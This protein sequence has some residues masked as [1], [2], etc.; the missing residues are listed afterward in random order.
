MGEWGRGRWRRAHQCGAQAVG[1]SGHRALAEEDRRGQR[2]GGRR[3]RDAPAGWRRTGTG[4]GRAAV[5]AGGRALLKGAN[6]GG[7]RQQRVVW[8]GG[9]GGP[10]WRLEVTGDCHRWQQTVGLRDAAAVGSG[11]W[12]RE[13]GSSVWRRRECG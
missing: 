2:L 10:M 11:L 9:G 12:R 8:Q 1:W 3:R 4:G 5:Q 13:C 7:P 6:G